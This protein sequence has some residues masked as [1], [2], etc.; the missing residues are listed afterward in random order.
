[1]PPYFQVA[2]GFVSARLARLFAVPP[3]IARY[4]YRMYQSMIIANYIALLLHLSW[5]F[6]F[7]A[8]EFVPLSLVNIGSVMLWIV[9]ITILSRWGAMLTAVVL[10]SS[11][12]LIHQFLAV[13]YLG[14]D[15]GFQYYLLVIVAFT[16]LM[17][18]KSVMYIPVVLFIVCLAS[19]LGFY[20]FVQYW[21]MPHVDLGSTAREPAVEEPGK[22]AS[23]HL[24]GR[25]LVAN[26]GPGGA[27]SGLAII[28][29]CVEDRPTPDRG[30]ATDAPG[31]AVTV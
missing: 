31:Q 15:Y 1:M 10:G 8:L 4:D 17:N 30:A 13:Y 16:F 21:N 29:G 22:G 2:T 27:L 11:E 12:V 26:L 9:S 5:V 20:Y 3:N 18:F 6:I 25:P 19:F 24:T 28:T 7:Y 23:Q 14:W